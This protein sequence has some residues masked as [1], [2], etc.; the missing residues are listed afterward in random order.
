MADSEDYDYVIVGAGT[1]GCLLANRLSADGSA[2]V[3]DLDQRKQVYELQHNLQVR[4]VAVSPAGDRVATAVADQVIVFALDP[5]ESRGS[6][7]LET[8]SDR[9]TSLCFDP[10]GRHLAVGTQLGLVLVFRLR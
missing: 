3:W 9:P 10:D 6:L 2:R 4:A 8:T 7:K 1:A 5:L